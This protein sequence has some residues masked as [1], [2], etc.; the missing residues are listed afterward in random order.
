MVVNSLFLI[1]VLAVVKRVS[2]RNGCPNQS[3]AVDF[4]VPAITK[5]METNLESTQDAFRS[6]K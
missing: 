3:T 1:N 6:E 2:I 4:Q 5:S